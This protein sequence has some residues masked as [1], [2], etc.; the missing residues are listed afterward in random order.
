M[1]VLQAIIKDTAFFFEKEMEMKI[2]WDKGFTLWIKS[3]MH[4]LDLR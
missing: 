1:E 4:N 2:T 3:V